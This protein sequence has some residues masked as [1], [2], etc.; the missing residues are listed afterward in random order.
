[1]SPRIVSGRTTA[2]GRRG[3]SRAPH[4]RPSGPAPHRG[5][6]TRARARGRRGGGVS[7]GSET[8]HRT[9]GR[10]LTVPAVGPGLRSSRTAASET[11]THSARRKGNGYTSGSSTS[12]RRTPGLWAATRPRAAYEPR[13]R[14]RRTLRPYR[15]ACQGRK[16]V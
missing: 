8:M 15:G 3:R 10:R 14:L 5:R 11:S 7:N 2:A 9:G 6:S 16:E 4:V 1:M 13:L 12:G